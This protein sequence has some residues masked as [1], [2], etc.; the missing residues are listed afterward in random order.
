MTEGLKKIGKSEIESGISGQG[1]FLIPEKKGN[2]SA[3]ES[4]FFGVSE[5]QI[6]HSTLP[7]GKLTQLLKMAPFIV[8]LPI[9]SMVI[10]HSFFVCLPG[11]VGFEQGVFRSL[12][13]RSRTNQPTMSARRGWRKD[14][15]TFLFICICHDLHTHTL[16][17][18]IYINKYIYII[19]YIHTNKYVLIHTPSI[20]DI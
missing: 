7:S 16:Y 11:R 20:D 13:G 12:G 10:F 14:H 6:S 18:Y 4:A 3:S 5:F 8:D 17:I 1:F 9:V 19:I 2:Q 15:I